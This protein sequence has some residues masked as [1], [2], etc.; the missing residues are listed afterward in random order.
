MV[1]EFAEVGEVGAGARV[2]LSGDDT[3]AGVGEGAVCPAESAADGGA[4]KMREEFAAEGHGDLAGPRG[5]AVATGAE[6]ERGRDAVEV[7][8]GGDD[9]VEGGR[10]GA[11]G[12]GSEI[13][14]RIR[15]GIERSVHR[16]FD[17]IVAEGVGQ[18]P[19]DPRK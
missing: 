2:F 13:R 16:F 19:S 1:D 15:I 12:V 17:L 4:G 10:G 7:G 8:D 11:G 6:G 9:G 5:F 14:I 3:L 18:I